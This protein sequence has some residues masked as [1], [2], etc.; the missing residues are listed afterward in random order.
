M[1]INK[2]LKCQARFLLALEPSVFCRWLNSPVNLSLE[3]IPF[4]NSVSPSKGY[5]MVSDNSFFVAVT[6]K[7]S[8]GNGPAP[9][10]SASY[11][12]HP[13]YLYVFTL[14]SET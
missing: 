8:G 7:C 11:L 4:L 6:L 3:N 10:T 9:V 1:K 2:A 5:Y 14:N 13:K 12:F